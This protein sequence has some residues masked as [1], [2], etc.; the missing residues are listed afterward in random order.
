MIPCSYK[1][2]RWFYCIWMTEPCP[3]ARLYMRGER[4]TWCVSE[5]LGLKATSDSLNK[6]S[7]GHLLHPVLLCTPWWKFTGRCIAPP[8]IRHA[9]VP[10]L[11]FTLSF[12]S[13]AVA[14]APACTSLALLPPSW[15]HLHCPR[16]CAQLEREQRI[17]KTLLMP[18]VWA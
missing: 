11:R 3:I 15:E 12:L 4:D 1:V 9:V 13:K 10:S 16:L 8:K 18:W 6:L 5:L 7:R 17:T 2:Q 14:R